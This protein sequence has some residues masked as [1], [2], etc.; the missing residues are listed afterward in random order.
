MRATRGSGKSRKCAIDHLASMLS[1]RYLW[2]RDTMTVDLVNLTEDRKKLII[3]ESISIEEI[4]TP[5]SPFKFD[6]EK[7]AYI[8]NGEFHAL[9]C[10]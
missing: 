4:F 7:M 9:S 6:L 3:F 10:E 5:T 8:E 1:A 2:N